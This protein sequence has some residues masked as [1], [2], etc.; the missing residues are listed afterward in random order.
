MPRFN[1]ELVKAA[2]AGR[3]GDIISSLSRVSIDCFDG[4]HQTCP[5]HCGKDYGG[6]DR[7][8]AMS[9]FAETGG[10]I[11]GECF[12]HKNGDGFATLSWLTGDDFGKTLERVAKYLGVKAEKGR[13]SADPT[14]KLEFLRWSPTAATLWAQ[15]KPPINLQALERL[16]SRYAKY[17]KHYTVI[18]IPVWGPQLDADPAVGWIIYR[19][20][21]GE[22]PRYNKKGEEPDWK[23]V[24]LTPGS[25]QGIVTCLDDWKAIGTDAAPHTWWKLEGSTDLLA[26]LSAAWPEGH[27]FFT[28]ANG[29]GE[30]PLDWILKALEGGN[31]NVCHD[32]DT[33][34]QS[35]ATWVEQSEGKKRP[36][37]CPMLAKACGH[38]RNV[39][40][41]FPV[42]PNHG[43]D[44]R[45]FFKG[46]GTA[47]TLIEIAAAADAWAS[48]EVE[49]NETPIAKFAAKF[50]VDE[51]MTID[52][53]NH[54]ARANLQYYSEFHFR[55][56]IYWRGEWYRYKGTNYERLVTEHLRVQVRGFV[57]DYLHACWRIGL[58]ARDS[59][60]A[61]TIP[62]VNTVIDSMK[63][64]CLLSQSIELD[65]WTDESLPRECL[66]FKNCILDLNESF[67]PS[68]TRG[69]YLHSHSPNW[70]SLT[71]LPYDFDLT[72]TCPNWLKF[73]EEVFC[74]PEA[75]EAVQRWFGYLL[76]PDCRL[77]KM[78]Y[79][80]GPTRSGKGTMMRVMM[81]LFGRQA[82]AS[83]KLNELVDQYAMHSLSGKTIAIIPDARLSR[84]ADRE[85]VT[86]KLLSLTAN[87]PQDIQRK[88]LDTLSGVE[89]N[90]RFTLFSNKLPDLDDSTAAMAG[91][92]IYLLMPNSFYEREDLGLSDRLEEELPGI[93]NWAIIGRHKL[94]TD[95]VI[96]QPASSE[97]LVK[98]LRMT[99]APVSQ[100]FRECTSPNPVAG[101]L[102]SD[103]FEHWCQW[104]SENAF[105][106]RMS[107][108]EFER[109]AIDSNPGLRTSV[110]RMGS[111]VERQFIGL[112][113]KTQ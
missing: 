26:A 100:F 17:L 13:K 53:P 52:N 27:E 80:I 69:K 113:L 19:S 92:G 34:G 72:K 99:M 48:D 37:W 71:C 87:D 75:I 85:A 35:G 56:L 44:I 55:S 104:A 58:D 74:D 50:P 12:S 7:F 46:G 59:V 105:V 82:I 63:R 109:K 62:M 111:S 94:R 54:L 20:D 36:G 103:V 47:A 45:D 112:E 78:L 95:P 3:W 84:R 70:F 22:L 110:V 30:K 25:R 67:K 107:V 16:G 98:H 5:K 106:H 8:R 23:K 33:P 42:E 79:I 18:A 64:R 10:V 68:A 91:R 96:R 31:V 6:K 14:D 15:C 28:T 29:A 21:G 49:K 83:P 77:H 97:H 88:Y 51:G 90:L 76:L 65:T 81:G 1:V 86:E 93:L 38:V 57:E 73:L 60:R 2:A 43:P 41:P 4:R 9:D 32:A 24:L 108:T 39:C 102:S 11:C 101:V 89:M 40:L 61:V 66:A